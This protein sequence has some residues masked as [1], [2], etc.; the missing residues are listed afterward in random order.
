MVFLFI[1]GCILFSL[2]LMVKELDFVAQRPGYQDHNKE[3][4]IEGKYGCSCSRKCWGCVWRV[5]VFLW[6]SF[7]FK[8]TKKIWLS[9]LVML[10][11]FLLNKPKFLAQTRGD[12]YSFSFDRRTLW[13]RK[14][15]RTHIREVTIDV[16]NLASI[17]EKEYR[18]VFIWFLRI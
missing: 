18:E 17:M 15:K 3:K 9:S 16:V 10:R 14:E 1:Y 2:Q 12:E 4:S 11:Q 6:L 8:S 5:V 7:L 13:V